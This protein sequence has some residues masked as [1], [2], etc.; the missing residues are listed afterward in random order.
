M[1]RIQILTIVFLAGWSVAGAQEAYKQAE[2]FN[3]L[4]K[5]AVSRMEKCPDRDSVAIF[6]AVVD[7]VEYS[8]KCDE[9]DRMPNRKG[10]VEPKFEE[11]NRRR[12][13]LLHPML[14]DAGKYFSKSVYT[15]QEG[16]D[17][18]K[19]YLTTRRSTLVKDNADESGVD[20][21]SVV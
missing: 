2:S 8:L 15:K 13:A 18:L 21:K 12:L 9:F 11:E 16:M 19:L 5:E 6:N 14:I 3:R 7:G 17:A 20:R 10:K 4:A 1:N